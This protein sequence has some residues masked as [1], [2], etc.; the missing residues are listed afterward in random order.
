MDLGVAHL[1]A[2]ELPPEDLIRAAARAGFRSVGLRICPISPGGVHYPLPP[3]TE[4]TRRVKRLLADEGMKVAEVEFINIT[5]DIDVQAYAA[6]LETGGELGATALSVAGE[7]TDFAR[8]TDHFAQLC[9]LAA[10]YGIRVDVEFMAWRVCATIQQA[11]TLVAAAARPNG[12]VLLDSLHLQRSGGVPADISALP[13]GAFG[14]AQVC[15]APLAGPTDTEGLIDEARQNRLLP[16]DGALPLLD[17]LR[18]LPAG[19]PI[20]AEVPMR[21]VDPQTR[22]DLAFAATQRILMAVRES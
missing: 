21:G 12:K 1:N 19:I 20:A 3:G 18:A 13:A 22:L 15:D 7:D 8:L 14:A 11:A 6:L 5:P 9:D 10:P 16:G 2:L 4:A 17:F